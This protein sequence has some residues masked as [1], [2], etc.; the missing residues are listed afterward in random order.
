MSIASAG[1]SAVEAK[2]Q[3]LFFN[4]ICKDEFIDA[5]AKSQAKSIVPQMIGTSALTRY[6]LSIYESTNTCYFE[7]WSAIDADLA[8]IRFVVPRMEIEH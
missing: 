8:F 3:L 1:P 4:S 7:K 6:V 2:M 5:L